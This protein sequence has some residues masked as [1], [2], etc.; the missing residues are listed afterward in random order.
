MKRSSIFA[1]LSL[2][3]VA[4]AMAGEADAVNLKSPV[5][6]HADIN[7]G[8]LVVAVTERGNVAADT[9]WLLSKQVQGNHLYAPILL[10]LKPEDRSATLK[11]L[12]LDAV[13]L[14]ALIFLDFKGNEINRVVA[15]AP[16]VKAF[17]IKGAGASV[18]N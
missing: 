3:F 13:E 11:S 10:V 9:A 16:S 12:K 2:I 6:S 4:N 7:K 14:P 15:A 5:A 8:G 1:A 18:L 17:Q